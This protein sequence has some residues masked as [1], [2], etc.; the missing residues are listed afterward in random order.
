MR[1]CR[2]ISC[3]TAFA[4]IAVVSTSCSSSNNSNNFPTF[5]ACSNE[6]TM[7]EGFSPACGIE[8]CCIDHRDRKRQHEHCVWRH[9]PVVSVVRHGEPHGS[10]RYDAHDRHHDSMHVL[11][12]DS[13]RTTGTGGTCG[14]SSCDTNAE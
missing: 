12:V 11:P 5:Q 9:H 2:I 6:H 8:I 3:A 7:T 10:H 4:L 13:G 1:L 14:S